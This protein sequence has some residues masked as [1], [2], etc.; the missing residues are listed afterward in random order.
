MADAR[1][2]RGLLP[3]DPLKHARFKTARAYGFALPSPTYPI[4]KNPTGIT[5]WGMGG[6]GPD[7]SLTI[8]TPNGPGAPV[9]DCGPCG[10]PFH[11]DMLTAAILG[12]K[13]TAMTS[14]QVVQLYL[15]YTGGQDTGVDLGDWLLWLFN[16]GLIE[17]FL[18]LELT[19][20]DAALDTFDV[21]VGGWILTDNTDQEFGQG[22]PFDVSADFPPDPSEGHCM[23][24][25]GVVSAGGDTELIT[26]G[27]SASCTPKFREQ[28]LQQAFAVVTRPQVEA[29]GGD[30]DALIADLKALG[31]TAVTPDVTPPSPEPAP[32]A[33]VPPTTT[34]WWLRFL[35]WL[36]RRLGANGG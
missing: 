23:D 13:W 32:P 27:G 10:V 22:I 31:G 35:D 19:E 15:E 25:E 5:D 4:N 33:P 24:F 18:K 30:F 21:V 20:V 28:C 1:P 12:V 3:F 29:Q 26:W 36:E 6:N 14:N 2:M 9:G 11:A 7:P 17:G 16:K 34:S 8:T